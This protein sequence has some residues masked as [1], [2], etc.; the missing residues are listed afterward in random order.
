MGGVI[1][2]MPGFGHFLGYPN[3][4]GFWEYLDLV[5]F[6]DIRII[7]DSGNTWI[8]SLSGVP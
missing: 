2:G 7:G 1:P 6:W 8:W 4:R 3:C 5:T